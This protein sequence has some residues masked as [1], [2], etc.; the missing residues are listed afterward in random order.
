MTD[1]IQPILHDHETL[2]CGGVELTELSNDPAR[3]INVWA[4]LGAL[5]EFRQLSP[6][7]ALSLVRPDAGAA[8]QRSAKR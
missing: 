4:R 8:S 1:V 5:L 2:S 3:T 6:G 7:T